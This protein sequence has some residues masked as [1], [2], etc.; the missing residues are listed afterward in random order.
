MA[1][2]QAA[3]SRVA[4]KAKGHT[5]APAHL[6]SKESAGVILSQSMRP[7]QRAPTC[8]PAPPGHSSAPR[9]SAS[10]ASKYK[11]RPASSAG[12]SP[13]SSCKPRCRA[14]SA[15]ARSASGSGGWPSR[16]RQVA[17]VIARPGSVQP[18]R[19]G[20]RVSEALRA[21][22]P[23]CRAFGACRDG[24]GGGRISACAQ[25]R[26]LGSAVADLHQGKPDHAADQLKLAQGGG[27]ML[28][29]VALNIR[30]QR[31]RKAGA[32]VV[33]LK[34]ACTGGA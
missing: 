8:R 15:S 6:H 24:Q 25:G 18:C 19:G 26:R 11:P 17:R 23:P 27:L 32:A 31:H 1:A 34:Q 29:L 28:P 21:G 12:A 16:V 4:E 13:L 30:V 33:R 20:G 7:R 2:A 5:H 9:P 14:G 3:S 10:C 22:A